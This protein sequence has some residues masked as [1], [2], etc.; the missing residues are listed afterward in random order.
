MSLSEELKERAKNLTILYVEDEDD[1]RAQISQILLLF[2]HKVIIASDGLEALSFYAK[3]KIDL[4]ITDLT[5]P[6]MDGLTMIKKI[7]KINSK[8]NII[9]STAHNSS[10]NL[11]QTIDLQLDGFLLKPIKMDKMLDLLLKTTHVINL[12]KDEK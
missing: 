11:M 10:E 5:M 2:F 7:R 8:Q 6:N 3:N 9:V 12:L 1:T 4:I